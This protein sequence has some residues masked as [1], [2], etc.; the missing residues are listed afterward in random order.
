MEWGGFAGR[1]FHICTAEGTSPILEH[2]EGNYPVSPDSLRN[3]AINYLAYS[4]C[5]LYGIGQFIAQ[6]SKC[7]SFLAALEMS[8]RA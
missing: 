7:D 8:F 2:T 4:V 1:I 5:A 6:R 3:V